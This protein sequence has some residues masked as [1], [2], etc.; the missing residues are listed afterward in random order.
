[1]EDDKFNTNIFSLDLS[2]NKISQVTYHNESINS[3]FNISSDGTKLVYFSAYK[4]YIY[5]LSINQSILLLEEDLEHYGIPNFDKNGKFIFYNK[6]VL[7]EN[8]SKFLQIFKI[9]L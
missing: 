2:N 6:Y 8:T 1:M 3:P 5:D 9:E 7:E 4:L